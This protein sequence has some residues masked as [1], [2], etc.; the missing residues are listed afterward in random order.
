M[1]LRFSREA[2]PRAADNGRHVGRQRS[3]GRSVRSRVRVM[4]HGV[5]CVACGV[6]GVASRVVQPLRS[7]ENRD[8]DGLRPYASSSAALRPHNRRCLR[9]SG[10][11][12][13]QGRASRHLAP[14]LLPAAQC[15]PVTSFPPPLPPPRHLLLSSSARHRPGFRAAPSCAAPPTPCDFL[16]TGIRGLIGSHHPA[17][18]TAREDDPETRERPNGAWTA[19]PVLFPS[20]SLSR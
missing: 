17:S 14:R 11:T 19:P 18:Y 7:C 6:R 9:L 1:I 8:L 5:W 20:L 4:E 13:S 12:R 2:G 15:H 3:C 16:S 10:S